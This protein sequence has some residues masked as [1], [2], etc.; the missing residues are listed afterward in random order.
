VLELRQLGGALARRLPGHGATAGF[1]AAFLLFACGVALDA[2][3]Y[4]AQRAHIDAVTGALAPYSAAGQYL[5]FAEEP[6]DV[7]RS[8][9]TDTW[10]RLVAVKD[11]VDPTNMLHANHAI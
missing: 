9:D 4:A 11:R 8:F 10:A 6:V 3:M 1:D 5:N 7:S 2:P